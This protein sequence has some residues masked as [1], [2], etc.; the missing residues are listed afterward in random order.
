MMKSEQV[1]KREED[2][3]AFRTKALAIERRIG[4]MRPYQNIPYHNLSKG[5]QEWI[6]I[7]YTTVAIIRDEKAANRFLFQLLKDIVEHWP[8]F[9]LLEESVQRKIIITYGDLFELGNENGARDYFFRL[10][11]NLS[12]SKEQLFMLS[13]E[14]RK[15]TV[16]GLGICIWLGTQ[17]SQK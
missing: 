5:I 6:G 17:K 11:R 16:M 7:K 10:M 13:K 12:V 1:Q 8:I 14:A 15:V 9:S 3:N 2:K 4:I